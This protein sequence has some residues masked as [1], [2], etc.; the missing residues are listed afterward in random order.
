VLIYD[1]LEY[2]R[3]N[4]MD[5]QLFFYD[6]SD[7]IKRNGWRRIY[8]QMISLIPQFK[9]SNIRVNLIYDQEKL[10]NKYIGEIIRHLADNVINLE[11]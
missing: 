7:V 8:S 2:I 9:E 4:D 3:V 5:V 6:L 11:D 1:L 10:E